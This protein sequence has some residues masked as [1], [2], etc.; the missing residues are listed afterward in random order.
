[1]LFAQQSHGHGRGG[2][3]LFALLLGDFQ[4]GREVGEFA[5]QP[6]GLA[7]GCSSD[8]VGVGE[9]PFGNCSRL[10]DGLWELIKT[11]PRTEGATYTRDQLLTA[12][13]A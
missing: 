12:R 3:G 7:N 13:N 5:A 1:M 8:L 4:R 6:F 11:T 10:P 2:D 9:G